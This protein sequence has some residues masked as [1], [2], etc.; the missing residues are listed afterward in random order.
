MSNMARKNRWALTLDTANNDKTAE[1]V[2]ITAQSLLVAKKIFN[3]SWTSPR[4]G[5]AYH[6][7]EPP[8]VLQ[9][10]PHIVPEGAEAP[11]R[12]MRPSSSS[13]WPLIAVE[14]QHCI[15]WLLPHDEGVE[16][17]M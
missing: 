12:D 16:E 15:D 2:V 14:E 3:I 8:M 9:L 6:S 1:A 11:R 7:V 17:V 4:G 13:F 5:A 10:L